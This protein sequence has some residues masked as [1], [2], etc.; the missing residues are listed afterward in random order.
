MGCTSSVQVGPG[1]TRGRNAGKGLPRSFFETYKL[2]IRLGGGNFAQVYAAVEREAPTEGRAVKILAL[3][4]NSKGATEKKQKRL[5]SAASNEAH[6]WQCIGPSPHIVQLMDVFWGDGFCY[7]VMERCSQSFFSWLKL[8]PVLNE[9][10]LGR[11]FAQVLQGLRHVHRADIVHRDVKPDNW[12][13]CTGSGQ[14]TIKLGDFGLSSKAPTTGVVGTAPYM[15]PELIAGD[16]YGQEVDIW[17]LAV[18]AYVLFFGEFPYMPKK[19]VPDHMKRAIL[20][21]T[22]LPTFAPAADLHPAP[23]LSGVAL[24]FVQ[25]LLVRNPGMRPSATEALALPY[26]V[27]APHT[28]V[29]LPSLRPVISCAEKVGAFDVRPHAHEE[30]STCLYALQE[31]HEATGGR[32]DKHERKGTEA[33]AETTT[34]STSTTVSMSFSSHNRRV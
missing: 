7:F 17:S 10:V 16:D 11:V 32:F 12:M 2:G 27:G 3:R 19:R 1:P 20:N 26:M 9:R 31:I 22:Q 23:A 14:T 24:D 30:M 33:W 6:I 4:D 15:A 5:L 25:S 13:V 28:Q 8:A 34:Q 18:S 21:P 29:S